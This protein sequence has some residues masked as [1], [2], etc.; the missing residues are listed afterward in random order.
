M[1]W[2][3]IEHMPF[4]EVCLCWYVGNVFGAI[5]KTRALGRDKIYVDANNPEYE[6]PEPQLFTKIELPTYEN[7][8]LGEDPF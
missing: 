5:K 3:K 1:K 8:E 6:V 2:K 4:N 7:T